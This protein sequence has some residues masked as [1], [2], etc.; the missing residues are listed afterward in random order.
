[1]MLIISLLKWSLVK[2]TTNLI[3]T[4]E[5]TPPGAGDAQYRYW[6][7]C[8]AASSRLKIEPCTEKQ[9]KSPSGKASLQ[10]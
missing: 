3:G 6:T 9:E 7:D 2:I 8:R 10:V 4:E 1:M 5:E